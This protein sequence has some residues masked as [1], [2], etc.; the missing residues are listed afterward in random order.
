MAQM[1]FYSGIM[2][3]GEKNFLVNPFEKIVGEPICL[4][5][6]EYVS[7]TAE[8]YD[9]LVN[10]LDL[11]Y[12]EPMCIVYVEGTVDADTMVKLEDL[13][14]VEQKLDATEEEKLD[15]YKE[16]SI[17]IM[18]EII[19]SQMMI[20][21]FELFHFFKLNH[22]L[23]AK[24]IFIIDENREEEYMKVIESGDAD[25]LQVL[26]EYL[27]ALDEF[28]VIDEK[29]TKYKEYKDKVKAAQTAK[30]VE[31]VFYEFTAKL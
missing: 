2:K 31:E 3:Q 7:L 19:S 4:Q 13:K 20:S 9:K 5:K 30:E 28:N 17:R 8:A 1:L 18:N 14:F 12:R 10:V 15:M 27:D 22:Y 23:E 25:T 11:K 24:G 29:Y 16:K 6:D 21:N 26:S